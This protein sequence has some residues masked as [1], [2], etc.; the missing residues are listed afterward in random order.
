MSKQ[1]KVMLAKLRAF[2]SC[3]G[4]GRFA[5]VIEDEVEVGE[6]KIHDRI[7]VRTIVRIA[8][9]DEG[10]VTEELMGIDGVNLKMN[11]HEGTTESGA[12]RVIDIRTDMWGPQI[13]IY[14]AAE[15]TQYLPWA[16]DSSMSEGMVDSS[17]GEGMGKFVLK[18][19]KE[20]IDEGISKWQDTITGYF[21]G[22]GIP[23]YMWKA[24]SDI[25]F[26]K[27]NT[28]PIWVKFFNLPKHCWSS[29]ALSYIA[30]AIG[31]PLCLD[32]AT[33]SQTRMSFAK[34]CIEVTPDHTLPASI[35]VDRGDGVLT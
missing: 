12:R 23:F 20:V 35:L 1:L 17:M 25:D 9:N 28:I 7:C 34:V 2:A 14:S 32:N 5:D 3:D 22:S 26:S 31:K 10:V 30:S 11:N 4:D 6:K 13:S 18:L 16:V 8:E 24:F 21:V 29:K 19:P 33:E 27:L 15:A